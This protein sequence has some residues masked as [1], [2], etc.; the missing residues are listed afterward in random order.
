[1]L[2]GRNHLSLSLSLFCG[3]IIFSGKSNIVSGVVQTIKA[4]FEKH[5]LAVVNVKGRAKGTSIQEVV[6]KLEVHMLKIPSLFLISSS[7]KFYF[8]SWANFF[9]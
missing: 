7:L 1:M 4:H 6:S 8:I 3:H 2:I 9:L 5:P